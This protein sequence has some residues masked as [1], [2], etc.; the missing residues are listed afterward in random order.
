MDKLMLF[1]YTRRS[2]CD[3][4]TCKCFATY[5]IGIRLNRPMMVLC[6]EHAMSLYSGMSSEMMKVIKAEKAEARKAAENPVEITEPAVETVPEEPKPAAEEEY[7]VCK[8]CGEKF[9]KS[10][11]TKAQF[12]QHSKKCKKE[13]ENAVPADK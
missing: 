11:M 8:Y 2:R 4:S 7:Y 12:A 9:P 5:Q 6:A 3:V 1:P 13:H 10:E